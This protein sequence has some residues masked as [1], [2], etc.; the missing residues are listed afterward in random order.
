MGSKRT[1]PDLGR[2][3]G[4]YSDEWHRVHL[5]NPRD[6][7]PE[8]NM[9]AYPWLEKSL[10]DAASMPAHMKGL[11]TLG[12]P[13]S[14]EEI[15]KAADEVKGKTELDALVSY[16]QVLGTART[17][18][19]AA[20]PTATT[21]ADASVAS[22]D[23]NV[24][25]ENGVVKFFFASGKADL[26]SGGNDALAEVVKALASGKKV[27]ISGYHDSTGNLATN[28]E[29]AKKRALAVRDAL[30]ALGAKADAIELRKPE[31]TEG[32]GN[33]SAARR[34]EVAVQN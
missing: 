13:Y 31:V 32:G 5:N 1:G 20:A 29:L 8:S 7:V 24:V 27:T 16:L 2:V 23:S 15:A 11:R 33:A 19:P 14:D 26:A 12:V 22:G 25:V 34:V 6:V 17:S 10:V 30:V 9:P 18:A 28:Q 3:G 4:R 21:T